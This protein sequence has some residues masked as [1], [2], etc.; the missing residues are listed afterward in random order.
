MLIS[1]RI[2][3]SQSLVGVEANSTREKKLNLGQ[4]E[5]RF[6]YIFEELDYYLVGSR[7][8]SILKLRSIVIWL[9]PGFI[10]S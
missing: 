9:D 7:F 6:L 8:H 2:Q 5:S 3:A 1:G 4:I 10:A